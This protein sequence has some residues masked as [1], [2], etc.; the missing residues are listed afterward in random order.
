MLI[1]VVIHLTRTAN[2]NTIGELF[3]LLLVALPIFEILPFFGRVSTFLLWLLG[4]LVY[5]GLDVLDLDVSIERH[6]AHHYTD[7]LGRYPTVV[8]KIV[9]VKGKPHLL[10]QITHE[11]GSKIIDELLLGNKVFTFGW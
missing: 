9:H 5:G 11:N 6:V 4:K 7:I 2:E 8:V 3:Y 1:L 10:I